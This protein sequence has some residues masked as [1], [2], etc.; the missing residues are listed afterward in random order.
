MHVGLH[1]KEWMTPLNNSNIFNWDIFSLPLL[2]SNLYSSE[3]RLPNFNCSLD[4]CSLP[5]RIVIS[6]SNSMYSFHKRRL[7][8]RFIFR[9][10]NPVD[11]IIDVASYNC[12]RFNHETSWVASLILI[13]HNVLKNVKIFRRVLDEYLSLAK[14]QNYFITFRST[15]FWISNKYWIFSPDFQINQ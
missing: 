2:D 1:R 8:I 11:L 12:C 6:Y 7:A 10:S 14:C 9:F 5:Y 3:T 15:N 13:L 4:G